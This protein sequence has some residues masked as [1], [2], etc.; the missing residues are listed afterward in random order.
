M[1]SNNNVTLVGRIGNVEAKIL[2]SGETLFKFSLAVTRAFKDKA[3]NKTPDWINCEIWGKRA[4]T[5][6][7]ILDKG[8]CISVN[9]TLHIDKYDKNGVS[10]PRPVIKVDD[11][12]FTPGSPKAE[13]SSPPP[14]TPK[15][16]SYE[17]SFDDP[18]TSTDDDD[19]PF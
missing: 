18:N 17:D 2:P 11:F 9:G 12:Q 13:E 15:K 8:S 1:A 16:A 19:L 7:K 3:G 5:A 10:I 14:S 6:A 4:E